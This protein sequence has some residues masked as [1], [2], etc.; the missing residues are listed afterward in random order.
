[1][2]EIASDAVFRPVSGLETNPAPDGL[3]IY[4]A[5]RDRVH[6]LNQT[7]LIVFELC[8]MGKTVG[9]IEVFLQEAFAL[10]APPGEAVRTCLKS[11]LDEELVEA[12][13][14]SS[15]AP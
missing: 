6:F 2:T 13:P 7:A 4:Q 15:S 12:C 11:L 14:P 9:A 1:M 3:M 10:T 8:G 5:A